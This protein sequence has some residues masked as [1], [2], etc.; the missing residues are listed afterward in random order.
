MSDS[1]QPRHGVTILGSA[2]LDVVF[3]VR[4]IP[5]PG[6]TLLAESVERYPGG[7]G[8]NQAVAAARSGA[9]TAFIGATAV[10][11]ALVEFAK[12]VF[13]RAGGTRRTCV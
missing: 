1:G 2:N 13:Y 4:R 11:L 3:T 10:Y 5:R 8:L 9:E 7:K 6:E 12:G